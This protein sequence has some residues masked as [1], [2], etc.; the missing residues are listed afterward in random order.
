MLPPQQLYVKRARRY[1]HR[2]TLAL[3][4]QP[5]D[6][7]AHSIQAPQE[8]ASDL[9][10][11]APL[12]KKA[13]V[14]T[15]IVDK[16]A[17]SQCSA[18]AYG[19]Y[20]AAAN[21][22]RERRK[23]TQS[24]QQADAAPAS[25]AFS[26][27]AATTQHVYCYAV[28]S[29]TA[30]VQKYFGLLH[31]AT[32]QENSCIALAPLA[33]SQEN[34]C[35]VLAPLCTSSRFAIARVQQFKKRVTECTYSHTLASRAHEQILKTALI[36]SLSALKC[37]RPARDILFTSRAPPAC[38]DLLVISAHSL[39]AACDAAAPLVKECARSTSPVLAPSTARADEWPALVRTH[40]RWWWSTPS[41]SQSLLCARV[42][43]VS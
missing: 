14:A 5:L 17:Q 35:V 19:G 37:S 4:P 25:I 41:R 27:S 34:L 43:V 16:N 12:R 3:A 23:P 7:V 38:D 11:L 31:I 6:L 28:A 20:G 1:A 42:A 13:R 9:Q 21:A 36:A 10:H 30:K 29:R 8:P 26:S 24:Q 33:T 2:K 39:S 40:P 32:S 22:T 15:R 18:T